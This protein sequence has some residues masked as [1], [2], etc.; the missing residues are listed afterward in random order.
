[1]PFG[2]EVC[3]QVIID[4]EGDVTLGPEPSVV[5]VFCSVTD[6][7]GDASIQFNAPD[8]IALQRDITLRCFPDTDDDDVFTPGEISDIEVITLDPNAGPAPV[9]VA[10][11][12]NPAAVGPG[13]TSLLTATLTNAGV[14]TEVCFEFFNNTSPVSF[15][16]DS[17][18]PALEVDPVCSLTNVAN[19]AFAF[20]D[21]DGD[22]LINDTAEITCCAD[23]NNTGAD[24]CGND[25]PQTN[26]AVQ[27]NVPAI[28]ISCEAQDNNIG[29]GDD[30]FINITTTG[31]A[32]DNGVAPAEDVCVTIILNTAPIS[33]VGTPPSGIT[34]CSIVDALGN[35]D[36][37]FRGGLVPVPD[38]AT[39]RCFI[40]N[41]DDGN[42][43]TP[44]EIS[45]T[46]QITVDPAAAPPAVQ[47][48]CSPFPA[49][50]LPGDTSLLTATVMNAAPG[51]EVCFDF[52]NNTS[53]VSGLS[54]PSETTPGVDAV[55]SD[56][57]GADQAFATFTA[58]AGILGLD[59]ANILCCA[60]LDNTP[61]EGCDPGDPQSITGVQVS[62]PPPSI[63]SLS[64]PAGTSPVS[65]AT[66]FITVT[67]NVP[68][69]VG[70][71]I[72]LFK[73]EE[74]AVAPATLSD[75]DNETAIV[76]V[77]PFPAGVAATACLTTLDN[78][79]QIIGE[80]EITMGAALN[81]GDNLVILGCIDTNAGGA[82]GFGE[83]LSNSLLFT[84][85]PP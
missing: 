8:P 49:S 37:Q 69:L 17:S 75:N 18:E 68:V 11:A 78:S 60:N 72:C 73:Q 64:A 25:D 58:D 20:F 74:N 45:V 82:C 31:V 56:T 62:P 2:Q 79:G 30:T 84:V 7:N 14:G 5:D 50:V 22:I 4:S 12:A 28:S 1:M 40:D 48:A 24:G 43:F 16:S 81:T 47:V 23:L 71:Q 26:V 6:G 63:I 51:T 66:R 53:P 32:P 77:D 36:V 34:A 61:D 65:N 52:F 21:A 27:V 42:T 83:P 57:N 3:A 70:T 38:V 9:Q 80:F 67:T 10:C 35:A 19:Q 39:V 85:P 54:D 29:P 55:C 59:T 44:G 76:V 46:E 33:E 15:L 13:D 41:L